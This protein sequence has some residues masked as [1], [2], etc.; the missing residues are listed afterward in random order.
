MDYGAAAFWEQ[1]EQFL[2]SALPGAQRAA[3][4]EQLNLLHRAAAP[5]ALVK[6]LYVLPEKAGLQ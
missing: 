1:R 5:R 2:P 4:A 6:P 3:P